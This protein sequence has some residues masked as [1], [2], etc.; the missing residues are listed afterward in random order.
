MSNPGALAALEYAPETSFAEASTTFATHRI[1]VLD[2]IDPSGLTWDKE[3]AGRVGQYMNNG[4]GGYVLM[5]KGGSFTTKLDLTGHGTT[6][7]GSPTIS[8]METL[9][10]YVFGKVELSATASTTITGGTAAAPTTTASATFLAGS[11]A[12][13]GTLGD[14]DGDSQ[15]YAVSTHATTTL[16]LLTALAGAPVN[17]DV[18]APAVN[19]Y[20]HETPY[21]HGLNASVPALRFRFLSSNLHYSCRGCAPTA[22]SLTG[23]SPGERPQ[24]SI[25]WG[26][27]DWDAVSATFP[28]AVT[29]TTNNP[30]VVAAGTLWANDVGT[31]THARRTNARGLTIDVTLGMQEVRAFGGVGA[32][33]IVRA[34]QRMPTLVKWSWVEDADA[35]T[36]SPVLQGWGTGT[37]NKHI[38]ATLSATPGTI[39]GFY[40]PN[41]CVATVPVQMNENG[42]NTM[43]FEGTAETGTTTTTDLTASA[44]RMGWA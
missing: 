16:N 44:F 31:S 4:G 39:V 29:T 24:I 11:L 40:S 12:R 34:W 8:A 38:L 22:F 30:A 9:M 42:I 18:L 21:G 28:S 41:V 33:Q 20:L 10:G 2:S 27:A 43:K 37:A 17:A 6:T 35:T 14:G 23:L 25:T 26:V 1:P 5:G 7:V 13:I 36:A 32:Y 3:Q 15:L 19:F